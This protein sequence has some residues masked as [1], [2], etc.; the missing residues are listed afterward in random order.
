MESAPVTNSRGIGKGTKRFHGFVPN[1]LTDGQLVTQ[2]GGDAT[3]IKVW[4]HHHFA[5]LFAASAS[6]SPPF[7]ASRYFWRRLVGLSGM[8]RSNHPAVTSGSI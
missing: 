3:M 6:Q 1:L 2:H 7:A 8:V 4:N 5:P